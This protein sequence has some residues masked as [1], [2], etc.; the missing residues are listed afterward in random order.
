[1][2]RQ[3]IHRRRSWQVLVWCSLACY[4]VPWLSVFFVEP[5][6]PWLGVQFVACRGLALLCCLHW[7]VPLG[8]LCYGVLCGSSQL[9]SQPSSQPCSQLTSQPSCQPSFSQPS[10]YLSSQ[11]SSQTYSQPSSQPSTQPSSQRETCSDK[12]TIFNSIVTFLFCLYALNIC[13]YHGVMLYF[14]NYS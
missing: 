8:F 11:P 2:R 10:D 12:I 13:Y 4:A 6:T 14:I 9:R 5:R 1:M 3:L 7:L